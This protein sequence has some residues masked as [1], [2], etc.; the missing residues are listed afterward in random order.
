MSKSVSQDSYYRLWVEELYTRF[1]KA[2]L[3]AATKVNAELLRF[4]WN[5]GEDLVKKS[6]RVY[7]SRAVQKV[8]Q[9]VAKQPNKISPNNQ[10]NFRQITKLPCLFHFQ[11]ISLPG[12]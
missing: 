7:F 12:R 8:R 4:Y 2:R 11:F 1:E 9:S 5:V 10:T 3:R 6:F